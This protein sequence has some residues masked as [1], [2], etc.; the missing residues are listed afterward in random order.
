MSQARSPEHLAFGEAL[1][2][3]RE[4]RRLS[5]EQLG[6]ASGLHRNYVGGVERG[7]LNPTLASIIKLARG[8]GL[9]PSELVAAAEGDAAFLR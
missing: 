9:R 7:E 8:L 4:E 1:R 3:L 6:Y 2:R 5:Q